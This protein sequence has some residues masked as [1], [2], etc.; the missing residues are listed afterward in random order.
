MKEWV[1]APELKSSFIFC[2]FLANAHMA[3]ETLESWN[4]LTTTN[5]KV[6]KIGVTRPSKCCQY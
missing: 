2:N 6:W 5:V 3:N 4:M 1:T